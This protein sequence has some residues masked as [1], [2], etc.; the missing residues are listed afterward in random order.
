M[1]YGNPH[2]GGGAS[3]SDKSSQGQISSLHTGLRNMSPK[4]Y[5]SSTRLP[6]SKTVDDGA[7]RSSTSH[8]AKTIG[9]RT[10]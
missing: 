10:A 9:P 7:T 4:C 3:N 6:T 8:A 5:D 1:A 2:G